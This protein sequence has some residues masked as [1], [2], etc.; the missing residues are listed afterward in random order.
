MQ[1][2]KD[3]LPG[4][5]GKALNT[6]LISP[7]IPLAIHMYCRCLWRRVNLIKGIL[8]IKMGKYLKKAQ[9]LNMLKAD[10]KAII[11]QQVHPQEIPEGAHLSHP[12]M[13]LDLLI[14]QTNLAT[15]TLI[16]VLEGH[17]MSIIDTPVVSTSLGPVNHLAANLDQPFHLMERLVDGSKQF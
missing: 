10:A 15:D 16:G 3:C 13:D 1:L 14:H 6:L 11:E 2:V 4:N 12:A 8:M 9:V 5:R 17:D 7:S